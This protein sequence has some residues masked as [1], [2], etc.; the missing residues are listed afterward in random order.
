VQHTLDDRKAV[1]QLLNSGKLFVDPN[2]GLMASYRNYLSQKGLND[3]KAR[4]RLAQ[5]SS[6]KLG[7]MMKPTW[8]HVGP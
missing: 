5:V 3:K 1:A 7:A 6:T 2:K 8:A 4:K